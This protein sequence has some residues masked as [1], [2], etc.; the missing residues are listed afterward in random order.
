MKILNLYLLTYIYYVTIM[1]IGYL[2]MT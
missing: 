1:L 2:Y